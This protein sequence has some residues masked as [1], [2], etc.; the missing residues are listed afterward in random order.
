M[1]IVLL[2]GNSPRHYDW[3]RDLGR[4]LE[5]AGHTVLLHDYEHWQTGAPLADISREVERVHALLANETGYMIIAKSIGTVIATVATAKGLLR[6]T[7]CL[8]LGVPFTGIAGETPE[9][10]PGLATLP[11]TIFIQNEFDP[12]GSAEGLDTLLARSHPSVFDL[13]VVENNT[14]HDYTDFDLL[15]TYC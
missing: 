15:K 14:T 4:A 10:L 2:G 9:F 11:R 5:A 12:Y 13:V 6:P 7:R 3:I 8:L 1:K